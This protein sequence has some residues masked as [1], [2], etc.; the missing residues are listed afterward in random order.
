MSVSLPNTIVWFQPAAAPAAQAHQPE[1]ANYRPPNLS[2]PVQ[3]KKN[4]TSP[5]SKKSS[6]AEKDDGATGQA[7]KEVGTEN[8]ENIDEEIS[9]KEGADEDQESTE[10]KD[11][12]Q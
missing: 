2:A 3:A 1:A 8:N 6:N 7:V 12:G 5:I 4:S 10:E 9:L 11:T